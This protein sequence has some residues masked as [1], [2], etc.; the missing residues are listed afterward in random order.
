MGLYVPTVNLSKISGQIPLD[1][2]CI[3]LKEVKPTLI[4]VFPIPAMNQE[5]FFQGH[6]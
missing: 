4:T 1:P 5:E 2:A 6:L 3:V